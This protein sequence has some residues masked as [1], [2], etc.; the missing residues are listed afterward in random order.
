MKKLFLVGVFCVL[1]FLVNGQDYSFNNP[2]AE[3]PAKHSTTIITNWENDIF[4]NTDHYFTN[5]AAI[6]IVN[7]NIKL[8]AIDY[9]LSSPISFSKKR[10][11][12]EI[13]QNMYTP[14]KMSAP[15]IQYGDRPFCG[16][17]TLT[18]NR[19]TFKSD[20]RFIAG[21]TV[22]TIGNYS[23]AG[24]T[25]NFIHSF[26]DMNQSEGWNYQ[27]K[28]TPVI[29]L[30]YHYEHL[31]VQ[32]S[33]MSFGYTAEG[34]V[35]SLY[36]DIYGGFNLK[37]GKISSDFNIPESIS[38]FQAYIFANAGAVLSIYDATLQGGIIGRIPNDYIIQD[39]NKNEVISNITTGLDVSTS[40]ISVQISFTFIS[41]EFIGAKP[42]AWGAISIA[43]TF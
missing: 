20:K 43:Y 28:N 37:L 16:Y 8:K 13:R 27:I 35:G 41:P 29:N 42:H 2:L 40:I 34:R 14:E 7:D 19:E 31:L 24:L 36:T 1:P 33:F 10:Y 22:G 21:L 5:G 15:G 11:S 12:L 18:Y 39:I 17:L 9:I 30:K 38:E 6:I 4:L 23:G 32:K 25:Q 3:L 26:N